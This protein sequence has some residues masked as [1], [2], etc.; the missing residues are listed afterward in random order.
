[1]AICSTPATPVVLALCAACL[2]ALGIQ[3]TRMG[4]RYT[5]PRTGTLISI[6]TAT[7]LY[8]VVSPWWLERHYWLSPAI[9]LFAAIGL[10]RPF[11]SSNL[12]MAGTQYLGATISSTLASTSPLF[13]VALGVL[14]LGEYL[15]LDIALGTAAIVAGVVVLSW[16]GG[17]SRAWPWWAL[18]LPVGAALLRS[19]AQ[20]FAKLGMESL[21]SPYFVGLVGYSV[22][23]LVA[24]GDHQRRGGALRILLDRGCGWLVLTGLSYGFAILS[25]NSA[26]N[27][28]RLSVVAPI[29][30][31]SPLFTLLL[32]VS[33]FRER[34]VTRRVVL[35]VLLVVPGVVLISMSP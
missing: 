34:A 15:G 17:V 22:S 8:W 9:A 11:L 5:D 32:G 35:A 27:C 20:A 4:L 7:L 13:G 21:P 6:G 28:G 3:F 30:A 16:R 10:F 25:L 19:V 1:M 14:L 2:F 26:L 33:L 18:L 31:C 24:V 23:F 12:S 29:V